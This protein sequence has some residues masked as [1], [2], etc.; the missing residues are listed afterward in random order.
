[1]NAQE[2]TKALSGLWHGS[3]GTV[4]C[5]AHDNRDPNLSNGEMA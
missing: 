3:Y 4:C 5:P 1:M 2:I